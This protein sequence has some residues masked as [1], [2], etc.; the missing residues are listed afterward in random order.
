MTNV[1][2][3]SDRDSN[4]PPL[5]RAQGI[6]ESERMKI[7][8]LSDTHEQADRVSQAVARLLG[9]GA[10]VLFHC[11]D[12]TDV[13]VVD[14]CRPIETHFVLGNNDHDSGD[15]ERAMRR[16]G[17][18]FHDWAGEVTL[19]GK[20]IAFTHGHLSR[21]VKRLLAAQPDYLFLGHSHTLVDRREGRTRV[22]NPGALY[23]APVWTFALLDLERD[24]LARFD[25]K[26]G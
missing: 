20:R 8:I 7:G 26:Q 24:V 17:A 16:N 21:E 19:A 9:E 23:R 10:R 13:E 15:L 5:D 12:L 22:I 14:A 18:H 2:A 3:D 6:G 4:R 11:G 1:V 25:L